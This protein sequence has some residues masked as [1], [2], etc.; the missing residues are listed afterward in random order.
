MQLILGSTSPYKR[1][2]LEEAG[3]DF[4]VEDSGVDELQFHQDT[5]QETVRVLA[6]KKAQAIMARHANDQP[7]KNQSTKK[8]PTKAEHHVTV[9]TVSSS[10]NEP[11]III[12]TDVAGELNGTFLGKPESLQQAEEMIMSYSGREV[13]IWCGTSVANTNTQEIHTNVVKATLQFNELDP[14]VVAQYVQE[15]NPIDKGGAIAIEEIEDRG[16]VQSVTGEYA[17]IIG[18]SMEFVQQQLDNL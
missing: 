16:F 17:A 11:T 18:I 14:A 15:K 8:Q 13:T 12:T 6:E 2:L 10:D 5:V 4:S 7:V 3:F 1:R 9:N